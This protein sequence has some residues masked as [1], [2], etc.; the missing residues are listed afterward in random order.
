[1]LPPL[2]SPFLPPVPPHFNTVGGE[3][4]WREWQRTYAARRSCRRLLGF[5]QVVTASSPPRPA[6]QRASR[7]LPTAYNGV[8][9]M[10]TT[11]VGQSGQIFFI[12]LASGN[13][14]HIG[15]DP[16][17]SKMDEQVRGLRGAVRYLCTC[18]GGKIDFSR[19]SALGYG[20]RARARAGVPLRERGGCSNCLYHS[21]RC[22]R[23]RRPVRGPFGLDRLPATT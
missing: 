4:R 20:E 3:K 15:E 16:L 21:H 17:N 14:T 1:M 6:P 23:R 11:P 19:G 5:S 10:C 2:S 12:N 8:D 18:V 9:E 22:R 13:S 7:P